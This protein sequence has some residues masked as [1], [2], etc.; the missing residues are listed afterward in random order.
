MLVLL[1]LGLEDIT[2]FDND[3]KGML[4]FFKATPSNDRV[5]C[6]HAPSGYSNSEQLARGRFFEGLKNYMENR[7]H[8]NGLEDLEKG[9]PRFA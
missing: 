9:E 2:E 7:N 8:G 3:P 1:H 5:L 4:V 6:V